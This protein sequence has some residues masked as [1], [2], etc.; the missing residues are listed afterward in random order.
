MFTSDGSRL[1]SSAQ[2]AVRL[3]DLDTAQPVGEIREDGVVLSALS[4]TGSFLVTCQRPGKAEDG[5][6]AKNLKV[7][8]VSSGACLLSLAQKQVAKDS[9]P[10][11]HWTH[12]DSAL[13]HTVT[14]TVHVYRRSDGFSAYRK[15]SIKGI[16]GLAL[17]LA[18]APG[19]GQ[20]PALAAFLP[21]QKGTPAAAAIYNSLEVS[22]PQPLMRKSFF[23]TQGAKL[24]WN[25]TGSACLVLSYADYDA[26]NQSYYGEQKL[27]YLPAD[28]ARA[29]E[30]VTVPLPKEGPV[31][32]VQW[33]P[34]GDYFI[35]VAGFMPAK[36][37]LFNAACKPVYDLG[38]GPYNMARWNPFGRFF[39]IAGFG[40]LPGDIVFYD[41]KTSGT[42]KQM[43]AV[44]SPAVAAEWSPDGRLLLTATTSPRLRVDNNIKVFTY[45]GEQRLHVPFATLLDA[46]WRPS[47]PGAF[48]DRPQSPER[49]A[50]VA[51]GEA[52]TEAPSKPSYVPPHLRAAGGASAAPT[53]A[54]KFSLARDEDDRPGKI[55]AG[56][57]RSSLPPGADFSAAG[58][59]SKAASKNAKRRARK[60]GGAGGGSEDPEGEAGEADDGPGAPAAVEQVAAAVASASLQDS[61]SAGAAAA[62]DE[63]SRQKR[64]RALQKKQ[65][66]IQELKDK[67]AAQGDKV[68]TPE[69]REKLAGEKAILEEL[70]SLGA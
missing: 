22:E 46:Q 25:A 11:L 53:N 70:A 17:S 10:V 1:V 52:S 33:S 49:L 40:N 7:W 63:E 13:L 69:Q 45:F 34:A 44:R 41:K 32:D 66:Q 12:D 65:R 30:A 14:N 29:D 18:P 31:H 38:S 23:R 4:S 43:G 9:W 59:N 15:I 21:E 56:P 6:P 55:K 60:K 26:T 35:T 39:V 68:L 37:T 57:G 61:Q 20:L 24:L 3:L 16:G 19:P 58:G 27:H 47:P 48:Q 51:K 2:G 67:A 42:C 5:S 64:I 54:V 50:A 28:P 8:D 36:V 62:G